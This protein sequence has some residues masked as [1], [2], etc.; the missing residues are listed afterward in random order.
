MLFLE[1]P[2]EFGLSRSLPNRL[3]LSA[4][5]PSAVLLPLVVRLEAFP[6][7]LFFSWTLPP[8]EVP[9]RVAVNLGI[10]GRGGMAPDA[11]DAGR[12]PCVM[13]IPREDRR[14]GSFRPPFGV[15]AVLNTGMGRKVGVEGRED[16]RED[17][18]E[19]DEAAEWVPPVPIVD[20]DR[21]DSRD[22]GR[23]G[24]PLAAEGFGEGIADVD[25]SGRKA[26]A[27]IRV[28]L[29]APRRAVTVGESSSSSSGRREGVASLIYTQGLSLLSS[30]RSSLAALA[31]LIAGFRRRGT[32]VWIFISRFLT[33]ARISLTICT[34]F[35]REVLPAVKALVPEEGTVL[36]ARAVKAGRRAC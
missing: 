5:K 2:N 13:G 32:R 9:E 18:V 11:A 29:S 6:E 27:G 31:L 15:T 22:A 12:G 14:S 34:P 33:R 17:W 20:V 3:N 21:A 35:E 4:A 25:A 28:G 16:A 7:R 24:S 23:R 8:L 26:A 36:T 1:A 19:T 30:S 10:G